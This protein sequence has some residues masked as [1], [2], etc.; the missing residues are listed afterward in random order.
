MQNSSSDE[1]DRSDATSA[2]ELPLPVR[3]ADLFK[4]TASTHVLNF[5]ADNPEINVSIRQLSNVTPVTERATRE[6]VDALE[7]NDL[8]ETFHEGTARRVQVNRTRLH[9]PDDPIEAIPQV[10]FRTPIRVAKR[11]LEDEFDD[12][13]GIVLFGSASRGDADRQSDIDLWILVE[14]DLLEARHRANK[15]ATE[16]EELHIP[17]TVA[18]EE[19]SGAEF[20]SNWPAIRERLES[21]TTDHEQRRTRRSNDRRQTVPQ[22]YSFEFVVETPQSILEQSTRVDPERLFG[23]GITLH[24]TETLERVIEEVI[25]GE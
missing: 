1:G 15:L 20:A 18:L 13:L 16:L 17:S 12:L 5:L 4:H 2:I 23:E 3:G 19:V 8:V 21:D 7:T 10:Q 25:K 14:G 22:R 6:A 24:F 9:K 11:Y